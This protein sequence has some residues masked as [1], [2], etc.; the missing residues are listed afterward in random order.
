MANLTRVSPYRAGEP[1]F[2]TKKTNWKPTLTEYKLT[3]EELELVKQGKPLDEIL[4]KR[5]DDPMGKP[6]V[7]SYKKYEDLQTKYEDL[8]AK[9]EELKKQLESKQHMSKEVVQ[10]DSDFKQK[11]E[12]LSKEHE[13][14]I[15]ELEE[16]ERTIKSNFEQINKL[17]KYKEKAEEYEASF[18]IK[19]SLER[20]VSAMRILLFEKL[21]KEVQA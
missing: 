14:L 13:K 9:C 5:E 8:Q 3:E 21:K 20:E 7:V 12:E 2:G 17:L 1:R 10:V 16:K 11:Y 18:D 6:R 4:K 15:Y 19:E